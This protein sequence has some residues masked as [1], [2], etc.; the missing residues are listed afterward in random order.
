MV[1]VAQRLV[2]SMAKIGKYRDAVAVAA[3]LHNPARLHG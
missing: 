3:L 1:T 2:K